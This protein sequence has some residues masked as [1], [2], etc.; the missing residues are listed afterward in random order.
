MRITSHA[1]TADTPIFPSDSVIWRISREQALVLGGPAAAILQIAHPQVALGVANHS[2]FKK[3]SLSRLI[4]TLDAV[5]TITFAPRTQVEAMA[6]RVHRS[7]APV[8]GTQPHQYSAFSL[9]AQM[10]VLAT[11]IA[12]AIQSYQ[13]F[14]GPFSRADQESYYRDMRVFGK[15]FGLP[16]DYGPR[17]FDEF[18]SYYDEMINGRVLGSLPISRELAHHVAYPRRPAI[19]RILW[20]ISGLVTR[21]FLPSPIRERLGFTGPSRFASSM[22][23]ATVG[24]LL[25]HLPSKIRFAPQYLEALRREGQSGKSV[26]TISRHSSFSVPSKN[27]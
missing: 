3:D 13:R 24:G 14:V 5:Y 22:I 23:D 2:N 16:T 6:A 26:S 21:E 15:F 4:R 7:H 12:L 17:T 20:P 9:D 27:G 8:H 11:L 19:L 18:T 1:L 10:W 25:P